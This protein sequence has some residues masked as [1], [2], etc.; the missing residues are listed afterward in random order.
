MKNDWDRLVWGVEASPEENE[1]QIS[2]DGVIDDVDDQLVREFQE[3]GARLEK[4]KIVP[5][6][7]ADSQRMP[8][9]NSD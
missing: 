5:A 6:D 1:V 8:P 9:E 3:N 7:D 4:V 2:I